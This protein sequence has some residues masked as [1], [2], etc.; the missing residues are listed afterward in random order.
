MVGITGQ[1]FHSA[2]SRTWGCGEDVADDCVR[3]GAGEFVKTG[4][5][6][7]VGLKVIFTS[8][9]DNTNVGVGTGVDSPPHAVSNSPANKTKN[10]M[11]FIRPSIYTK[12]KSR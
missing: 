8:G 3:V 11:R 12:I 10:D 2:E 5:G 7:G 9:S 4:L 6:V 1:V